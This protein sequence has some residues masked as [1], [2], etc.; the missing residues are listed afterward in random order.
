MTPAHQFIDQLKLLMVTDDAPC[1]LLLLIH[2]RPPV[3]STA[4]RSI[5]APRLIRVL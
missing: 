2:V 4:V 3:A 5:T 1:L